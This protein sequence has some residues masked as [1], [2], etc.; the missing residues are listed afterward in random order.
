MCLSQADKLLYYVNQV[1]VFEHGRK[2]LNIFLEVV[3][4]FSSGKAARRHLKAECERSMAYVNEVM[5]PSSRLYLFVT[6]KGFPMTV[7][8][9][10][11]S[12]QLWTRSQPY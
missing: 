9:V 10:M 3:S 6:K 4:L 7:L 11:I 2:A 12:A 5:R 8:L 1:K